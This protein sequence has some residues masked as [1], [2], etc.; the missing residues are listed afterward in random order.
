MNQV[1]A[2]IELHKNKQLQ[3]VQGDLTQETVDA[4]VN[5]ANTQL[6]H[7]G[8]VAGAI[9]HNGGAIIQ[10]ESNAWVR[11][12][13]PVSH[14]Q[15]A[16]TSAGDLPCSYVIHAV[17]PVWGCGDEDRKLAAAIWGSLE[18]ADRLQLSSLAFPAISTG[19]FGFPKE[20]AAKLILG[21][22]EA[23]LTQ[24]PRSKLGLIRMVLLD[25]PTQKAFISAIRQLGKRL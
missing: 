24:N 21:T 17:G 22:I 4:I 11:E 1:I 16:Y 20:R 19:I 3:I 25:Q 13:G 6:Q 7:G 14:D 2:K 9:V 18:T 10:S 23:Y 12:Y 15:P 8:G 5:A